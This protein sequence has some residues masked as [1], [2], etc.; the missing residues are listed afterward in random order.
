MRGSTREEKRVEAREGANRR[1]DEQFK[2]IRLE[3]E[4]KWIEISVKR[5]I[6]EQRFT[7]QSKVARTKDSGMKLSTSWHASGMHCT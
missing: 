4:Y 1:N 3:D 2:R 7:N 5:R 6:G